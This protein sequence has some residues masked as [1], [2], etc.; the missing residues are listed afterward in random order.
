MPTIVAKCPECGHRVE[1]SDREQRLIDP[2]SRCTHKNG[3]SRC[4]N[5]T[6]P[7][8]PKHARIHEHMAEATRVVTTSTLF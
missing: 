8:F 2:S 1:V 3:W 7:L 4:A 5:L 6:N